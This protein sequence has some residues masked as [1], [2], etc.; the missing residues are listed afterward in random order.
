MTLHGDGRENTERP[1]RYPCP[2]GDL[3]A[4]QWRKL[5]QKKARKRRDPRPWGSETMRPKPS[6]AVYGR[7]VPDQPTSLGRRLAAGN[8]IPC[9]VIH[10]LARDARPHPP[11]PLGSLGEVR[12]SD[13][14]G[15]PARLR[16]SASG[17]AT[18]DNYQDGHVVARQRTESSGAVSGNCGR[19]R[20]HFKCRPHEGLPVV[21]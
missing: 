13:D 11:C 17:R 16:A 18:A 19:I 1:T 6:C 10:W 20:M 7:S 12:G 21:R 9:S 4:F 14:N 15:T 3:A 5:A 8:D 2:C